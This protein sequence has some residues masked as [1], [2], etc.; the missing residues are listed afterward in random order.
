MSLTGN[1]AGDDHGGGF[2]VERAIRGHAIRRDSASS[3]SRMCRSA[4]ADASGSRTQRCVDTAGCADISGFLRR[5][6]VIAAWARQANGAAIDAGR[7]IKACNDRRDDPGA[8]TTGIDIAYE[9]FGDVEAPAVILVMGLGG[10]ILGRPE[11]FC[12]ASHAMGCT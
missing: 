6:C 5:G 11:Q 4:E 3:G 10:Q 2:A 1:S 8:G 12:S 9:R 7:V